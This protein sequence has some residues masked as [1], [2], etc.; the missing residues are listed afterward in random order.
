MKNN[1]KIRVYQDSKELPFWNYK[2]IVQTG[3]FFYMVKGYEPGDEIEVDIKDLKNKFD[4][5]EEDY[6]T[7]MN[8]KNQDIL[9]HGELA[10]AKHEVNKYII[11]LNQI[12][13]LIK[14]TKIRQA[15]G[16]PESEEFNHSMIK[17][18]LLEFKVQKSDDLFKQRQFIENKIEKYNNQILK[19]ESQISRKNEESNNEEFDI[20]EQ[21]VNVCVGLEMSV[22]MGANITLYQYGV[23]IKTLIRKN[24]E[25]NKLNSNAR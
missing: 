25:L 19:L 18:L 23:M 11:I 6:A 1:N 2:R 5:I 22:D 14:C 9:T 12:D 4:D 17:E 10:I 20:D 24:E 7:S 3:D 8:V 13:L 16:L 21:H 15:A